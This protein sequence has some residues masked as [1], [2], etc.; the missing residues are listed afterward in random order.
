MAMVL[1]GAPLAV[2]PQRTA[3]AGLAMGLSLMVIMGY[4]LLW[5][6]CTQVAKSG[7]ALPQVLAYFPCVLMAT[8]GTIL[9]ARKS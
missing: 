6:F 5:T 4:Y 1:F 9:I 8:L 7:A 2:R 3:S